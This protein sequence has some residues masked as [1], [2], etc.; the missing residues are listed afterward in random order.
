MSQE[1]AGGAMSVDAAQALLLR[2]TRVRVWEVAFWLVA[3]AAWALLPERRLL[4]NEIAIAGL[5]ALSLD[6][7]LGYGGIVSLG[8]AAFF[9]F[10]SYLVG[11][12]VRV[13][14]VDPVLGLVV[15]GVASGALGWASSFLVLRGSDL[16]RIMVTL[17][18]SLVLF[19]VANRLTGL[20]GGADGLQGLAFGPVLGL[21]EFDLFGTVGSAYS[22]VVLFVLFLMARRFVHS[23]FGWSVRA[24]QGNALRTAAI[25]IPVTGRLVGIYTL[26]AAYA[27]VAG[28][29][30]AQT[31]QFVSLDALA[32]HRSADVLLMLVVGGAGWLYGGLIGA[33]VFKL[34]QDWLSALTPQFWQFWIGAFLVALV[35]VGRERLAGWPRMLLRR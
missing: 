33:A 1:R 18:V 23:P 14:L 20:T 29:L 13:G 12:L 7:V 28:A 21:F 10:G 8:H 24:V 5:F 34:M 32:F 30:L 35:L 2:A 26:A 27:G 11:I 6:L 25:G 9:G 15:A 22:L 4:V 17:S 19:E 3:V 31:T 16:T